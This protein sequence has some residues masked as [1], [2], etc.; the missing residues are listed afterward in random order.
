MT[1]NFFF[2]KKNASR[3]PKLFGHKID[4]FTFQNNPKNLDLSRQI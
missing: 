3:V 2:V 1:I 4:K